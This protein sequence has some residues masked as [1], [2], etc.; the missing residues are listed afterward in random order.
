MMVQSYP[1]TF[2]RQS[3]KQVGVGTDKLDALEP[4]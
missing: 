3:A 1:M 2:A 4:E